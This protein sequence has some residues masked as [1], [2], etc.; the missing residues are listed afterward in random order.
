MMAKER[1]SIF[2]TTS[3]PFQEVCVEASST[4]PVRTGSNE[5]RQ[6]REEKRDEEEKILY[7]DNCRR[8]QN[9]KTL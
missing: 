2:I 6:Q 5:G 1:L 7:Q 9:K 8:S 4:S 3:S